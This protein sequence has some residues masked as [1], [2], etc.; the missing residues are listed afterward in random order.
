MKHLIFDDVPPLNFSMATYPKYNHLL[1]GIEANVAKV[2]SYES[3]SSDVVPSDHPLVG[4]LQSVSTELHEDIRFHYMEALD[5]NV[6]WCAARNITTASKTAGDFNGVWLGG[7]DTEFV[8]SSIDRIP[9][10][11]FKNN[12]YKD[13][14]NLVP[15]KILTSKYDDIV[16]WMPGQAPYNADSWAVLS[17]DLPMLAIMYR[18]WLRYTEKEEIEQTQ[19]SFLYSYVL[20]NAMATHQPIKILNRFARILNDLP[21][22]HI[23][24]STTPA[25]IDYD[26]RLVVEQKKIVKTNQLTKY[27]WIEL[28]QATPI[29]LDV[30]LVDMLNPITG[31]E[32]SQN[33]WLAVLT[34]VRLLRY[35]LDNENVTGNQ[36]YVARLKRFMVELKRDGGV[37]GIRNADAIDVVRNEFE[38]LLDITSDYS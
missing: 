17:I 8:I 16:P 1:T 20:A 6:E 10:S 26:K 15:L 2:K 3:R 27:S 35:L 25:I 36:Q 30:T 34:Q 5:R 38:I 21:V 23:T 28:L 13:W 11:K 19:S 29:G 33:R 32:T 7:N 12:Q 24:G 22:T 4:I 18:G 9:T 37:M 14:M 31:A